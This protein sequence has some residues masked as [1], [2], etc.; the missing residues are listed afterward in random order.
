[1]QEDKTI[2]EIHNDMS[3]VNVFLSHLAYVSYAFMHV[4]I[5]Y[6]TTPLAWVINRYKEGYADFMTK[7]QIK[8]AQYGMDYADTLE[9]Q[10]AKLKR[11]SSA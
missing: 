10:K 4:L 11:K 5:D 6:V 2:R 1:M 9:N 7:K 3:S 8:E